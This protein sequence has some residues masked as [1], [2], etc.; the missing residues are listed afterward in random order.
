MRTFSG[1]WLAKGGQLLSMRV[2]MR[3]SMRILLGCKM[4]SRPTLWLPRRLS[5]SQLRGG[6]SWI[7]PLIAQAVLLQ[8]HFCRSTRSMLSIPSP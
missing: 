2:S 3:V 1:P 6:D 5:L 7:P 4:T 8:I